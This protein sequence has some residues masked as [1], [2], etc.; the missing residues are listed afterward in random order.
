MQSLSDQ[1]PLNTPGDRSNG[2]DTARDQDEDA[3]KGRPQQGETEP[4]GGLRLAAHDFR[5]VRLRTLVTLRWLTTAAQSIT[6]AAA[7]MALGV[8]LPLAACASAIGVSV[9]YNLVATLSGR[10][11]QRLSER[12]ALLTL[13]FDLGQLSALLFLSGGLTN[14]FALFLLGPVTVAASVLTL[15]TTLALAVASITAASLLAH[16]YV[17]LR[18]SDGEVLDPPGLFVAGYWVAITLGVA[19]QASYARRVAMEALNMSEALSATQAALARE[20][21]MSAIGALA[22]STAHEFGTPLATIK[23]TAE[24]LRRDLRDQPE[25]AEDAALISEQAARCRGILQQLSGV[26][27]PDD[28]QVRRAPLMTVLEEAAG[29]HLHRRAELVM[30]YNGAPL[31]DAGARQPHLPRRPEIIHGLRNL[32]QNAVDFAASTVWIDARLNETH[33]EIVIG[34]DGGGFSNEILTQ[35]G[36]PFA[37][38]RG[39][40]RVGVGDAY[41][42]MGLGVFISK[43]LLES[44]GAIVSF[45]NAPT[46]RDEASGGS[47]GLTNL[48]GAGVAAGGHSGGW[49]S[50]WPSSYLASG[51]SKAMH[52]PYKGENLEDMRPMATTG[53][54]EANAFNGLEEE[55]NPIDLDEGSPSGALVF[56]VW[57][58]QALPEMNAPNTAAPDSA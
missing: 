17:P 27:S 33:L 41:Q 31:R 36:E 30:R 11:T 29:P 52:A 37:T 22:A 42:G 38:T 15:R 18:L 16:Y 7:V 53:A 46:R 4:F 51:A 13:M 54:R 1:N 26:R 45:A 39:K 3:A 2:R 57:P 8:Q 5:S 40:G 50:F 19:F 10:P 25:L 21:R 23:L 14:P 20:Q 6:L 34:D 32:I 12:D 55:D 35:L 28:L 9:W 49:M 56:V 58:R 44:S 43:T 24:E 47:S 48:G